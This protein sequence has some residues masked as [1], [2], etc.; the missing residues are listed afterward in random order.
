MRIGVIFKIL[1]LYLDSYI[2]ICGGVFVGKACGNRIV[3]I[4]TQ[5]HSSLY[6]KN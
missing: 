5:V 6:S 4:S 3:N 2:G 1:I